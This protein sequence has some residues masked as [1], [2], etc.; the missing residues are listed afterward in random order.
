MIYW[1]ITGVVMV[2]NLTS[3]MPQIIQIIKRKSSDDISLLSWIQFDIVG[4]L[5]T[6]LM[7]MDHVGIGLMT[8]QIIETSLCIITT[9]LA[10]RYKSKRGKFKK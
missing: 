7:V 2:I 8:L 10:Y 9:I 3:Y 6:I 5:Y 4:I 1:I